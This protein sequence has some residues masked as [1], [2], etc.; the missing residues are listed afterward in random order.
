MDEPRH[1]SRRP[2]QAER[3]DGEPHGARRLQ[4]TLATHR[5]V[6]EG[7]GA[8]QR[9]GER[10]VVVEPG[11]DGHQRRTDAERHGERVERRP[12]LEDHRHPGDGGGGEEQRERRGRR[13][14]VASDEHGG[15]ERHEH[16]CSTVHAPTGEEHDDGTGEPHRHRPGCDR[17]AP[18]DEHRGGERNGGDHE[19]ALDRVVTVADDQSERSADDADDEADAVAAVGRGD[20]CDGGES[21]ALREQHLPGALGHRSADV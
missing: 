14:S 19:L 16:R 9:D 12:A 17:P 18:G 8:E 6:Q 5:A 15:G 21:D 4:P 13:A 10:E 2:R 20:Q 7:L 1:E 3:T 11:V